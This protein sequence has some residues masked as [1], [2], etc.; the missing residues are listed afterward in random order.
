[1]L[2]IVGLTLIFYLCRVM[3]NSTFS[4]MQMVKRRMF[5]MRNGV[6]AD[7]LRNAGSPFKIIF[8]LNL[9]QL[10]EI[11]DEFGKDIELSKKL[12]QNNTTRESML[13]ATM[14]MPLDEVNPTKAKGMI[15]ESPTIEI[16]DILCHRLL[17]HMPQ[18]Y[19][20]A[21][22]LMN[23]DD[24]KYRYAGLRLL[25][26]FVSTE[27]RDE[28]LSLAKKEM[29]KGDPLTKPLC[30]AIIEEISFWS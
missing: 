23:S 4:K 11:A 13:L 14:M 25:W 18:N 22:N 8:G 29:L 10:V 30:Q 1:M 16:I 15:D 26:H 27:H 5:A 24:S 3:E 21:C 20:F 19:H 2:Q 17:R 7:A 28:I 9:P 12:W 6:I